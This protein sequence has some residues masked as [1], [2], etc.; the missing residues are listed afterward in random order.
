MTKGEDFIERL[1][2]AISGK[3]PE[4]GGKIELEMEKYRDITADDMFPDSDFVMAIR[5]K[6]PIFLVQF[7]ISW[8]HVTTY[9]VKSTQV[10]IDLLEI[11]WMQK[12]KGV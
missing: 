2:T 1:K 11:R 6:K 4:L 8:E 7:G 9:G 12:Q 10:N 3:F 5:N